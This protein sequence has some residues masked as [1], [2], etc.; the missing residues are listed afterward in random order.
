MK[1]VR[2]RVPVRGFTLIELLVVI[3]IIGLL[4]SLVL[5]ALGTAKSKGQD[6]KIQ[7]QL[8]SFQQAAE[9]YY[10][11]NSTYRVSNGGSGDNVCST[12]ANDATLALLN[13]GSAWAD[14]T[15]PA[16]GQTANSWAATKQLTATTSTVY[17]C[18]DYRGTAM[19]TSTPV[20]SG[21]TSCK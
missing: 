17:W 5:A 20:G 8:H 6:A 10:S 19:A 1:S 21:V 3:A 13:S 14:G 12:A 16:C 9:L 2:V 18:V 4:S 11:K 15:P 7:E